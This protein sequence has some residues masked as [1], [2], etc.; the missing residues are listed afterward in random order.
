MIS[1]RNFVKTISAATAASLVLPLSSFSNNS[2]TPYGMILY[3]VRDEMKKDPVKTLENIAEIG[4]K[5]IEAAGYGDRKFY[6]MKPS[7]FKQKVDSLGMKLVSSH[8][9]VNEKNVSEIIEDA[10]SAGLEYVINPWM[11]S[12]NIDYYKNKAELFNHFGEAFKKAGIQFCYHNH[13]FEFK[14]TDGQIPYDILLKETNPE[15]VSF[16]MDLFWTTKAGFNPLDYFDKFPNRFKLWH[17]K[18]MKNDAN[19]SFTEIG[20]GTI[21]FDKIF[22]KK[23]KAGMNYYF[24]EQDSCIDHSPLESIKISLEYIKKKDY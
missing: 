15:F 23:D 12:G 5:V 21:N 8:H 3:T 22:D 16:E 4:F 6:G 11:K 7:E 19:K 2:K 14:L 13:D 17:V 24:V 1:R 10:N 9:S 20:N 18:D